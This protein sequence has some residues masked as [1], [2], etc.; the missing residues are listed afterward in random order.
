MVCFFVSLCSLLYNPR[1]G[2]NH[3]GYSSL[4]QEQHYLEEK[5]ELLSKYL[6][7]VSLRPLLEIKSCLFRCSWAAAIMIV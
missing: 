4:N 5:Q 1:L 6:L 2:E 3:F 7:K